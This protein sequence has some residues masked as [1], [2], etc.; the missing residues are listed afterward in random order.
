M[1]SVTQIHWFLLTSNKLWASPIAAEWKMK[2]AYLERALCIPAVIYL[3]IVRD[4]VANI[5][6]D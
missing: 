4:A 6:C 2:P 5:T 1:P 3:L